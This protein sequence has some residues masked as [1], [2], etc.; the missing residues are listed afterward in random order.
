MLSKSFFF[1]LNKITEATVHKFEEARG[2]IQRID[3]HQHP[4]R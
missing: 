4:T 1:F 2:Q 3:A